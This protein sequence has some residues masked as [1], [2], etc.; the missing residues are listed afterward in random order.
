M[1]LI[2][3]GAACGK[4]QWAAEVYGVTPLCCTPDE[5][6][7][8]PAVAAFQDTL[9]KVGVDELDA[10]IARLI[11]RNPGAIVLCDEVGMGVIP[12]A[13]EDRV[14]REKV[15]RACCLLQKA[16]DTVVRVVCGLPQV[17]KGSIG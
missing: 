6:L 2:V 5:A 3:G 8:R 7:L 14:W 4:E 1:K 17:L 15:G 16:S 13:R 12:L 10:Y 11:E 9:R